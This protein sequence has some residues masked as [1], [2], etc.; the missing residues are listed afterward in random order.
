MKA[1]DYA[2]PGPLSEPPTG[3]FVSRTERA[4][5]V[6]DALAG[7]DMGRHDEWLMDWLAGSVNDATTRTVVSLVL[8]ARDAERRS[9]AGMV[10]GLREELQ[11]RLDDET[12]DR[13]LAVEHAIAVLAD[14]ERH[15]SATWAA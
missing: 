10:V 6:L 12:R 15:L 8:R 4:L 5:A 14:I 1:R 11:S 13:Q 3:P 2:P 7:V 9:V